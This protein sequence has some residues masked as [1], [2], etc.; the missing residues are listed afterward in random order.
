M[1][2]VNKILRDIRVTQHAP[3][4]DFAVAVLVLMMRSRVEVD[5][6]GDERGQCST[7]KSDDTSALCQPELSSQR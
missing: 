4:L 5:E 2:I 3:L 1:L 7:I 6:D